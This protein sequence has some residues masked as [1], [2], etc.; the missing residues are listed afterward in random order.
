MLARS[1]SGKFSAFGGTR[2]ATLA[3]KDSRGGIRNALP[4]DSRDGY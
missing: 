3:N 2:P 4:D 1:L